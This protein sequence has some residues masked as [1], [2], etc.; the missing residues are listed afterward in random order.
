MDHTAIVGEEGAVF[1]GDIDERGGKPV[2]AGTVIAAILKTGPVGRLRASRIAV[3]TATAVAG[4]DR[5]E[6]AAMTVLVGHLHVV[7]QTVAGIK[8]R[9]V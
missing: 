8:T 1:T 3:T 4:I 7:I 5:T 6:T 2:R 9:G